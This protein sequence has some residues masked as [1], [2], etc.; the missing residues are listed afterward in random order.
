MS[1]APTW[2]GPWMSCWRSWRRSKALSILVWS[3]FPNSEQEFRNQDLAYFVVAHVALAQVDGLRR[4]FQAGLDIAFRGYGEHP[5]IAGLQ[6]EIFLESPR[7]RI[8]LESD[9]QT[10]GYVPGAG[11]AGMGQALGF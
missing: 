2:T 1:A 6:D 7:G 8:G 3:W 10:I 5:V 11:E 9:H 4:H